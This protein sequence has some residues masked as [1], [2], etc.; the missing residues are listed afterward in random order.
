M[1]APLIGGIQWRQDDH[2]RPCRHD[3]RSAEA[4]EAERLRQRAEMLEPNSLQAFAA[5]RIWFRQW[6]KTKGFCAR[7][8]SYNL[9]HVAEPE[10]GYSTDGVFIVVPFAEWFQIKAGPAV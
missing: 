7:G 2:G 5:A 10:I 8:S 9:K 6:F 4:L 3:G 1:Y